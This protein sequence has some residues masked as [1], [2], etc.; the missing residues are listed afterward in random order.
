ML[1]NS[2]TFFLGF[3][4]IVFGLYFIIAHYSRPKFARCFLVFSSL[5]FY[6]FWNISYLAL[7]AGSIG[8][9]FLVSKKLIATSSNSSSLAFRRRLLIFGLATNLALL[10]YFKY[11]NFFI[12][13]MNAVFGSNIHFA[14]IALPLA[15]SFFT[16]QQIAYLV[17]SY[18]GLVNNESFLNYS[19]FVVFFPQLIAGPIVHHKQMMPQF[20][21]GGNNRLNLSNVSLGLSIFSIGLFKKIILADTFAVWASAGF[22]DALE[23]NFL[24]SWATSLS[25]TFQLYFDF[26]GYCDMAIGAALLFNIR[27][28]I[29][30]NSPLRATGMIEFWKRW[31]MTLTSFITTYIYTPIVRSFNHLTFHKMM[32]ATI[33]AFLISGL[34]H[35][36]SWMFV[37]FGFLH[38]FGVV[39]NHYWKSKVKLKL[40]KILSWFIFFNYLNITF[41]YFRAT[42]LDHAHKIILSMFNIDNLVLPLMLEKWA[43]PL[44]PSE[45]NFG[46]FL[47]N[48]KG[49]PDTVF[50]IF[51]GFLI[52]LIP[53]NSMKIRDEF[54]LSKYTSLISSVLFFVAA[55][56]AAKQSEFLY[57]NF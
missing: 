45:V 23:L 35:G 26:S 8:F 10:G 41:V 54:V 28:P 25:Y 21:D 37:I 19:L 38:G 47:T 7:L 4:P 29:N 3:L 15:I 20:L 33:I 53:K 18:E 14:E 30:F 12:E 13:N 57:F 9:N 50:W 48:V 1:F 31:H 11:T 43:G 36:A 22:D 2:Y 42:S 17:D 49:G 32:I 56:Y 44:L 52:I 46:G 39:I 6:G 24:E 55:L 27:L 5:F 34:W 16:L 40:P 51:L